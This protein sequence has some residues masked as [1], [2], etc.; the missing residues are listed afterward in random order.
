MTNSSQTP[1]VVLYRPSDVNPDVYESFRASLVYRP[2]LYDIYNREQEPPKELSRLVDL[3]LQVL[4]EDD[5]YYDINEYHNHFTTGINDCK[6]QFV[7]IFENY[8]GTTTISRQD[9]PFAVWLH[10]FSYH[11]LEEAYFLVDQQMVKDLSINLLKELECLCFDAYFEF[12]NRNDADSYDTQK[13][14][15]LQTIKLRVRTLLKGVHQAISELIHDTIRHE[16]FYLL[17]DFQ[18]EHPEAFPLK[19]NLDLIPQMN[20]MSIDVEFD[21]LPSD[22][23]G[24]TYEP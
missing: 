14:L 15:F 21:Q 3:S 18:R 22:Q 6:M 12:D 8:N 10:E 16:L 13:Y 7:A 2:P 5:I 1:T 23:Y 24:V 19:I 17:A 11:N 4:G 9:C 20:G